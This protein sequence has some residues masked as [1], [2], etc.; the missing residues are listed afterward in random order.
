MSGNLHDLTNTIKAKGTAQLLQGSTRS[1]PE[2]TG[3]QDAANRT[4]VAPKARF[5]PATAEVR[6]PIHAKLTPTAIRQEASAR[7]EQGIQ[8]DLEAGDSMSE[9]ED[10][11]SKESEK[12]SEEGKQIQKIGKQQ[13]G[14]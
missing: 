2:P 9:G 6:M 10:N 4:H 11:E 8:G 7:K 13:E 5:I 3:T 14:M 12:S 1:H